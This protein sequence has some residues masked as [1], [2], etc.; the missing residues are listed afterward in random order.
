MSSLTGAAAFVRIKPTSGQNWNPPAGTWA[1]CT[2][3]KGWGQH[4]TQSQNQSRALTGEVLT[5]ILL[6]AV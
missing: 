6:T 4:V 3:L 1:W 2:S 5:V